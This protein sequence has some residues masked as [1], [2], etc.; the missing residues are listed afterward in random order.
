VLHS[1]EA[2]LARFPHGV[3]AD[4]VHEELETLYARRGQ[5][6]RALE[7]HRKRADARDDSIAR[8]RDRIAER[9]LFAA[10]LERHQD[11]RVSLYRSILEEYPDTPHAETARKRLQAAI[12]EYTPQHIRISREF[13][14]ESPELWGPDA[15]AL[16]PQLFDE[17]SDD[18][19]LADEGITLIGGRLVRIELVD[20]EPVT[21]EI[22]PDDFARF[23]ALLEEATYDRL[24]LDEREQP[25]PDPQRDLFFERARLGLA[26]RP[27][28]R[29]SA[30]SEA[31]FLGTTEKFGSVRQRT[32]P[33]PIEVVLQG[34]LEDFGFAAFPRVKLPRASPDSYLFR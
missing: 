25:I 26:D 34:G 19:E 29:R 5:W 15:L 28:V 24:L 32:S 7:H 33:L 8:Y 3:H 21:R 20:R 2:Y 4:E 9:T 18:G 17:E 10:E 14:E 11:A 6:S 27:D 22:P 13:L 12:T 30:S 1:G 16:N 31:V 23:I